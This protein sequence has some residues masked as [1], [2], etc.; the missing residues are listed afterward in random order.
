MAFS[1]IFAA[2]MIGGALVFFGF[3]MR[4][5]N[6]SENLQ[7]EIAKGIETYI[8]DQQAKYEEQQKENKPVRES[9][10]NS[11][12]LIDDDAILGEADA[13]LTMVEFSDY[14]CPFCKKYFVE[15]YP[16]IKK[17]YID[18]GKMKLVFRD[19]PL[20]FHEPM[21]TKE[22]VAAECVRAQKNDVAYFEYHDMLF[23]N[24]TSNGSGLEE[25][26]LAEFAN[27][28]GADAGEFEKCIADSKYA[29]EVSKDIESAKSLGIG[30]TPA[31]VIGGTVISGAQLYP[32]F[33]EV[34]ESELKKLTEQEN[35]ESAQ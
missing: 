5:A 17:N 20:S 35:A 33:E 14:E 12:E 11:A 18:T 29:D 25:S 28:L 6:S 31:F 16:S 10:V 1:I 27:D 32:T 15:T 23:K 3:Q 2:L 9:S 4:S 26:Q 13:P 22:A 19:L 8:Q 34:I 7:K 30:G 21:A 24:T